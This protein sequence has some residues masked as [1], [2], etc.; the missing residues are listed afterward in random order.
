MKAPN[1]SPQPTP[2]VGTSMKSPMFIWVACI[3]G[4]LAQ[5]LAYCWLVRWS[6]ISPASPAIAYFFELFCALVFY[7]IPVLGIF[8]AVL[9][10]REIRQ[11][12]RTL[13][14][15]GALALN[16]VFLFAGGLWAISKVLI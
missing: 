8:G 13:M 11:K 5:L 3:G 7:W 9:A 2:R 1:Q 4:F 15:S 12:D 6:N 10:V 14:T 16:V